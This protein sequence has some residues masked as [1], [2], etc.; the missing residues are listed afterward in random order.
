MEHRAIN[1]NIHSGF[2]Y[3]GWKNCNTIPDSIAGVELR[4]MLSQMIR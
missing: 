1:W 4:T 3:R 2:F